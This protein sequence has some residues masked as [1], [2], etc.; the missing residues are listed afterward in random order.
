[1]LPSRTVVGMLS[2]G[3]LVLGAG[4]VSGQDYPNRPIRIV[5]SA[6]G[7]GTDFAARIMAQ[8]LA[9]RLGQPVIVDNR[10]ALAQG[11]IVPKAPPDGYTLLVG[12]ESL[13]IS[14]FFEKMPHDP[15]RDF[16]AVTYA[17]TSPNVLVVIPSLPVKSVKDLIDLAKARKGDLDYGTGSNGSSAHLAGEL[18]KSMTGVSMVRIPHNGTGAMINS[19]LNGQVPLAFSNVTAGTPHIKS[20]KLRGVAVTSSKP[21]ALLPGLPTVAESLPGYKFVGDVVLLAPPGTSAPII[22]RLHR[23][24]VQVLNTAEVKE[25]LLNAGFEV[26]GGS[27]Q[28]LGAWIKSETARWGKVIKEAGLRAN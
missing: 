9:A 28:E 5:T 16:A 13:W 1:M 10:P 23:E 11:V 19:L 7:G 22:A 24:T 18:F 2:V 15:V 12:G 6:V 27:P 14:V 26:E 21:S 17:L 20:G 3:L 25:K 8:G 4:V